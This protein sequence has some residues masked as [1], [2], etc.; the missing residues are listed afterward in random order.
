M[1]NKKKGATGVSVEV[2]IFDAVTGQPVTTITAG[3]PGVEGRY[4]RDKVAAAGFT[5]V[6]LA[7]QDSAWTS[8]GFIHL[9]G[10]RYRLDVPD[11]ACAAGTPEHVHVAGIGTGLVWGGETINLT[12]YDPTDAVRLGLTALPNAAAGTTNGLMLAGPLTTFIDSWTQPLGSLYAIISGNGIAASAAQT[13][14]VAI[15]KLLEADRHID[16]TNPAAWQ[17][18]Y[19]EKGTANELLRQNLFDASDQ[20]IHNEKTVVAKATLAT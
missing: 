18:V 15:R 1:L 20:P 16:K 2:M 10:G 19:I 11:A 4:V 14:A 6:D 8:G 12:A 13:A 5:L 7:A 9:Y 17:L 3:S